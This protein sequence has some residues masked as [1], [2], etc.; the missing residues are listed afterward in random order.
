MNLLFLSIGASLLTKQYDD[1]AKRLTEYVHRGHRLTV[2]CSTFS[3]ENLKPATLTDN[4]HVYPTNSINKFF[5]IRDACRIGGEICRKEKFDIIQTQDPFATALVGLY[6]KKKFS[7]PLII[8][9]HSCFFDNP[10]WIKEKP[11]RNRLFNEMGKKLIHHADALRLVNTSEMEKCIQYGYQPEKIY[12]LPVHVEIKQFLDEPKKS[13]VETLKRQLGLVGK[14]IMVWVGTPSQKVKDLDTLLRA[15]A[16]VVRHEPKTAL[17]LVGDFTG[18]EIYIHK[19]RRLGIEKHVVF[20]GKIPHTR[21]PLYYHLSDFYVHASTYEGLARVRVEA[22]ASGKAV[23]STWTPGSEAIII[24][25][26]TGLL[27]PIANYEA[28]G[29]NMLTLLRNPELSQKMGLAGRQ[30]IS[31]RYKDGKM[32]TG[33]TE[34]WHKVGLSQRN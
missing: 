27:S 17:V 4:F 15:M 21:I 20:P 31:E 30:L 11:L 1:S 25:G 28:L 8:G 33:L 7:I 9:S 32:I 2:I 16:F 12:L 26:V 22:A 3:R 5:Y 23:V 10:F 6:L 13:D 29:I 34:M 24:N 14:K 18:Y 19:A